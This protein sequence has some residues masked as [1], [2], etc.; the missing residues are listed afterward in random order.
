MDPFTAFSIACGVIQVVD[1]ST[2]TLT[3]CKEIYNEG[4]LSEH[5]HL[6][7]L[8][9]TLV[10]VRAKLHLPSANQN[11]G[12]I[13]EPYEQSL[14]NLATECSKTADQ[15][16]DKFHLLKIQ[17]PHKKRQAVM[18]TVRLLW[19]KGEIQEIQKRLD[20]YR[21]DLDTQILIS[22]RFV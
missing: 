13:Q 19:E 3:K 12:G 22:L 6:E 7:E 14:L 2:K 5:K 18:K 10:D 21:S 9:K 20:F 17:G 1:Y 15:L 4:S 8:A 16:I 11:A